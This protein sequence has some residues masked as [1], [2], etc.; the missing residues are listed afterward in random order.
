MLLDFYDLF[1]KYGAVQ[2]LYK[3]NEA[4]F[5]END[6]AVFF[7]MVVEGS[8]RMFNRNEE[9][10]EFIQ[11]DFTSGQSFGEPPLFVNGKY[12]TTATCIKDTTVLKLSRDNFFVLLEENPNLQMLFLK[13]LSKRIIGKAKSSKDIINQNTKQ[14]ILSFLNDQKD[15]ETNEKNLIPYTRQEIANF[16]GLRVETVIRVCS[17]LKREK[18]IDIIEHKIYF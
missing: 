4:I 13:I 18:I 16:T 12:P 14:K 7:F 5:N 3:K 6:R 11:G 17:K 9:G 8:I 10:K 1:I 15:T 2:K